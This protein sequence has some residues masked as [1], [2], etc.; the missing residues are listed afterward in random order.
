MAAPK[1]PQ[2]AMDNKEKKWAVL[3]ATAFLALALSIGAWIRKL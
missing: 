3:G 2:L 1:L